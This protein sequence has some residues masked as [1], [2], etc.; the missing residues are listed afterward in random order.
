MCAQVGCVDI[1]ATPDALYPSVGM[2][3]LGEEVLLDLNAEWAT[4]EDDSQMIVDSHEDIWGL[5]HDVRVTGTVSSSQLSQ[6]Q[7]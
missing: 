2:H 6:V 5:L 3:S 1:P 4:E 7:L